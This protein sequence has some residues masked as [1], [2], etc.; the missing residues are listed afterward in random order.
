MSF[1]HIQTDTKDAQISA[2]RTVNQSSQ[3][4]LDDLRAGGNQFKEQENHRKGQ[5]VQFEHRAQVSAFQVKAIVFEIA[6]HFF[7][8]LI[9]NDKFCLTRRCQLELTWWRRPLR[10]RK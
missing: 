4:V 8:G 7:N 6:E 3:A 9:T 1:T 10:L 2:V 5:T